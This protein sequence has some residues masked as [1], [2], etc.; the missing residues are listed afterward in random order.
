MVQRDLSKKE[1]LL[2]QLMG[3]QPYL[4]NRE[5]SR[6][7]GYKY[8]E[9]VSTLQ[10]KLQK[11]EYFSGPLMFADLGK[12][13]KNTV[14]R[15]YAFIM[16]DTTYDYVRSLLQEIDCWL[17]FYPME[18]G[19]FRKYMVG[20]MNSDIQEL[21]K[22]FEYLKKEGVIYYYH[23]FEQHGKW[24]VIN[25]TFLVG[26]R[27]APIKPD[28]DHL[29]A[30]T[31]VPDLQYG[32][33]ADIPL[34][35][36]AQL[37]TIYLWD[38]HEGCDIKKIIR[39][40]K[41]YREELRKPLKKKLGKTKKGE[42]NLIKSKLKEL[43]GDLLLNEFREAYKMLVENNI[44]EKVYYV[45]PFPHSQCSKFWLLIR[46]NSLEDTQR[47]IF[48]FG[49]DVRIFTRVSMVRSAETNE[50][51]GAV[52]AT[53]DTFLAGE[54]MT[55]L[56]R[57]PEIE[58]RKLFPARSYPSSQWQARSIPIEGYYS[59]ETQILD[60]PYSLFYERVKQKVEEDF[61][62]RRETRAFV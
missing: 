36:A 40:E 19:I 52:Y 14:S 28:F 44:L 48:N 62:Q 55:A 39:K 35:Y 57:Y 18:E 7:I 37:L 20:F 61:D 5:L 41:K 54:L 17:Y 34:N 1:K 4:T 29:S 42:R 46:S 50:W 56:D 60:Y 59:P 49:R 45:W 26:D 12:I 16:F 10:K 53:G 22:I 32:S 51:Y 8:A 15:V 21:R 3:R 23:L 9:Y 47:I 27:E 13:F 24:E 43:K 2:L 33:F 58:E 25:P 31:P 6:I 38:G 30:N 11:R